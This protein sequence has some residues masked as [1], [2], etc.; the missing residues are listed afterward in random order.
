LSLSNSYIFI[1]NQSKI[2]DPLHGSY[3]WVYE[4]ALSVASLGLI[5]GAFVVPG[6]GFI[7]FALGIVIP[8]HSHI[9]FG[10]VITD[11]LP[12]R[13]FPRIYLFARGL[14]GAATAG[15]IYGLYLYN[16]N[17]MGITE[18]VRSLWKANK[19]HVKED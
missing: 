7:D 11:Y 18:G 15:A 2:P 10:S 5:A 13:K 8:L 14:L 4:R 6:K 19:T 3:H 9:G 17:D 1:E 12:A 16:T